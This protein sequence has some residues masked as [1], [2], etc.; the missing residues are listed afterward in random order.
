MTIV[1]NSDSI[2]YEIAKRQLVMNEVREN[3]WFN[4]IKE[5]L[6]LYS[7]PSVFE[8]FSTPPSKLEWKHLLSK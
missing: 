8:L 5:L 2:E 3:I 6:E 4:H 1:C 7:I